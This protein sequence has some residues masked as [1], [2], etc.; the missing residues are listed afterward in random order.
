MDII[1][2]YFPYNKY[3]GKYSNSK[4]Y[5][6][7]ECNN[8][9]GIYSLLHCILLLIDPKYI[10]AQNKKMYIEKCEKCIISDKN[11][12]NVCNVYESCCN[13][14]KICI[15]IDGNEYGTQYDNK[16]Y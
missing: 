10:L 9:T 16:I 1:I 8:Y 7:Y 15:S 12:F 3:I 11:V 13:I 14:F 6:T 4:L 5:D 2:K